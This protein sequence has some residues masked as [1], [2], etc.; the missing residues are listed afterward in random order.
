MDKILEVR[1]LSQLNKMFN[2]VSHL[3]M[4]EVLD[5]FDDAC[6]QIKPIYRPDVMKLPLHHLV[7]KYF[8]QL[9]DAVALFKVS[10]FNKD[11]LI[12][13][14]IIIE[15]ED[16]L[17]EMDSLITYLSI[18]FDI[19]KEDF[20]E[21]LKMLVVSPFWD[22]RTLCEINMDFDH[23]RL[24]RFEFKI[25]GYF[26][27]LYSFTPN[28][29]E[30]VLDNLVISH[31]YKRRSRR[32]K[33]FY[34]VTKSQF[35]ALFPTGV[36][37]M[38]NNRSEKS[39][40][41]FCKKLRQNC[42]W[43]EEMVPSLELI[44]KRASMAEIYRQLV[45]NKDFVASLTYINEK[46]IYRDSEFIT[47]YSTV[48]AQAGYA[49]FCKDCAGVFD[50]EDRFAE[51][52]KE[53]KKAKQD[54]Q[55]L[56]SYII[57]TLNDSL[58]QILD[59]VRQ[60]YGSLMTSA[61][62]SWLDT[63][64]RTLINI[65][66]A[67]FNILIARTWPSVVSNIGIIVN[68]LYSVT[69]T[70]DRWRVSVVGRILA[71]V[72]RRFTVPRA[73]AATTREEDSIAANESFVSTFIHI[74]CS[75]IP[76]V[77]V[78]AGLLKA[79][80][81]RIE[82]LSKCL[83]Y[84]KTISEWLTTLY[85]RICEW[86]QIYLFGHSKEELME[87]RGLLDNQ[88]IEEWVKEVRDFEVNQITLTANPAQLNGD[89]EKQ[90]L[91]VDL[92]KRGED[93]LNI[94][95][96]SDLGQ[97]RT[98]VHLI[99]GYMRKVNGWYNTFEPALAARYDKDKP[100][101]V[102]L[103]G[104]PGVGK[105][106]VVDYIAQ[107]LLAL[108]DY[109]YDPSRDKYQKPRTSEYWEGYNSQ[110]VV[111]FD[112][113]LQ[114]KD[115]V[116]N[117]TELAAL[118][119]IGSR[120]PMPL[121]MAGVESKGKHYFNSPL[122]FF[123]SNV[124]PNRDKVERHVAE[125]GAVMRRIDLFV[126][127]DQAARIRTHMKFDPE[128]MVFT[129]RRQC[130]QENIEMP[131]LKWETF[132]EVLVEHYMWSRNIE[133]TK[134]GLAPMPPIL[135][136]R[137]KKVANKVNLQ[138]ADLQSKEVAAQVLAR[139]PNLI[140]ESPQIPRAQAKETFE[141]ER[142][143]EMVPMESLPSTSYSP[144]VPSSY[145]CPICTWNAD[146]GLDMVAHYLERT[147]EEDSVIATEY[148]S[149]LISTLDWILK[150]DPS[151]LGAPLSRED[152]VRLKAI[153][154]KGHDMLLDLP[155]TLTD[156][157]AYGAYNLVRLLL[158]EIDFRFSLWVRFKSYCISGL[159]NLSAVPLAVGRKLV[160]KLPWYLTE[161]DLLLETLVSFK[162]KV[163]ALL[164]KVTKVA[165]IGLG[166]WGVVALIDYVSH[167][168]FTVGKKK[169]SVQVLEEG[170]GP[171][172]SNVTAAKKKK[173]LRAEG[174]ELDE[175]ELV[176]RYVSTL[177]FPLQPIHPNI[178]FLPARDSDIDI[179][180]SST[181]RQKR[182]IEINFLKRKV[183]KIYISTKDR[184][185]PR[186]KELQPWYDPSEIGNL[187]WDEYSKDFCEEEPVEEAKRDRMVDVE[188][189]LEEGPVME[190]CRDETG[191]HLMTAA[192]P[193]LVSVRCCET[194]YALHGLFLR[195]NALLIPAHI[196]G[197]LDVDK[198]SLMIRTS[199]I[200]VIEFAMKSYKWCKIENKDLI[201]VNL[202]GLT[203]MH[204]DMVTKFV[205]ESDLPRVT[206]EAYLLVMRGDP[207]RNTYVWKQMFDVT[208]IERQ[209]YE[210]LKDG[211]ET[212]VGAIQYRGDS[213]IG[214]CGS[215]I[216][217]IN[218]HCPRKLLGVHLAGS[219]G[220]GY[221]AL[222][223]QEILEKALAS[224]AVAQAAIE[225]EWFDC[226]VEEF[227]DIELTEDEIIYN[228]NMDV[229]GKVKAC[230]L[231]AR[232][233]ESGL[234]SSPL[235]G[236][237]VQIESAPSV[238][239]P[240]I[241]D[242]ELVDPLNV[243][244][245]KL[246]L[247]FICFEPPLIREV[248]NRMRM[249]YRALHLPKDR[250]F[251]LLTDEENING[252]EGSKWIRPLNMHTSP[253]YPY[254]LAG[255]KD[256]YLQG[257]V[258]EMVPILRQAF[259]KREK[260]ALQ[261]STP[262]T[263]MIDTLKDER[264]PL[265]KVAAMKT[266]IFSNCP[267]DLN[268]LIRK[269]FLRFLAHMMEHHVL[270]E[271]SVGI[272]AHGEDWGILYNRLKLRG[273][274]WLAGDYAAWDKRTPYQLAMGILALVEDFYKQFK[275]YRPEH[276]TIRET[277]I[278]DCFASKRLALKR[279]V[280][281]LYQV[282]QSMPS[283]IPLTAVWNSL[284]N[285]LLFRVVYVL[286]GSEEGIPRSKLISNYSSHVAFAA[287]G[288]DHIVRV[289]DVVFDWFNM[290]R[291]SAC[292]ARYG[293]EYTMPDK[294]SEMQREISDENLQYLKRKFVKRGARIDAPLELNHILDILNW[295]QAKND[296]EAREACA[297]AVM[298]VFIELTHHSRETYRLWYKKIIQACIK[299]GLV[300]SVAD[301]DELLARR[302]EMDGDPTAFE[303]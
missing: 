212:I 269:Y 250:Q 263:I 223:T 189:I 142:G 239:K 181:A 232:M 221:S 90:V 279:G 102:Y 254:I 103:Y 178:H 270:W 169:E 70:R 18:L 216:F 238:L 281:C 196:F 115:D 257:D 78:D 126:R 183:T 297:S 211:M 246:E 62:V 236:E 63:M 154:M 54:G 202:V 120:N 67:F 75:M 125:F 116:S 19:K 8:Y 206:S 303:W 108:E 276:A 73:Q 107:A 25:P 96:R 251:G 83:N 245:R 29:R 61:L 91:V 220:V 267:L 6:G 117:N 85:T 113:F 74:L 298:S 49:L 156:L 255:G 283:G 151:C 199:R 44:E 285:S 40:L 42:E 134:T 136:N 179:L 185:N 141:S 20:D 252:I 184:K 207:G 177:P 135:M 46:G 121:D 258:R 110:K 88:R 157:M 237:V 194:G 282:H 175:H 39:C 84:T 12:K 294:S 265:A 224:L 37:K 35:D 203:P 190:A 55:N 129:V 93:Y 104:P 193:N 208:L 225:L 176:V 148:R 50:L 71:Q 105:T 13:K 163:L 152:Y 1:N 247:K 57:T 230:D 204:K 222:L 51:H 278:R 171:S 218:P 89:R 5:A 11:E 109:K 118:I 268:L 119:D 2:E 295:V 123:T 153:V 167:H 87:L 172:G 300:V 174:D 293:I 77:R 47:D 43:H 301:Y 34:C 79:R 215:P 165:M 132:L 53:C 41:F 48:R 201:L 137:L 97:A 31:E 4:N 52:K 122:V 271:V 260:M 26:S 81:Q 45:W 94:L 101:M 36:R 287:Y 92:K 289:S 133:V 187:I 209:E 161:K 274:H 60:V 264:L 82:G 106:Y 162:E 191:A 280:G 56:M 80:M 262:V 158:D 210:K 33:I 112:D 146:T 229:L 68:E 128:A 219:P 228:T 205:R 256:K 140:C 164:S 173:K 195:N 241:V 159:R 95:S 168:E 144:E 145:P 192:C 182:D 243:A 69:Q 197:D 130:F 10:H 38:S 244:L 7:S 166:I 14:D 249:E 160:S 213:E 253:G 59:L 296:D 272:N 149:S 28:Q 24:L 100:Y 242:G 99:E 72:I 3:P 259:E 275:D 231:P 290:K 198:A 155:W 226:D 150:Y 30:H 27:A 131:Y 32:L 16:V 286:I 292:M 235:Q 233:Y 273:S 124:E 284:V 22:T 139:D 299:V 9:A 138:H 147:R 186:T 266:R 180:F 291:I 21:V 98:L 76:G 58:D 111:I 240:Q 15:P 23:G 248:I 66:L 234:V 86:I 127:V 170:F 302:L 277:I 114:M 288:D 17:V 217:S 64:R 143:V 227:F 214:D 261:S 188:R 65:T 200:E